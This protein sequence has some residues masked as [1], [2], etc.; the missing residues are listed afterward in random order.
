MMIV[1]EELSYDLREQEVTGQEFVVFEISGPNGNLVHGKW[2]S[3]ANRFHLAA[4]L[5]RLA[6]ALRRTEI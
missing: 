4:A 2:E 1:T 3:G 6:I 5:E